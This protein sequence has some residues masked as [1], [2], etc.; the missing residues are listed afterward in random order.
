MKI[1]CHVSIQGG[2][3]KAPE[4]AADLGCE[5]MQMFTRSPQGG[6]TPELTKE[7]QENFAKEMKKH[8]IKDAYVH[9]PYFINLASASGRIYHGSIKAIRDELERASL[10]KAKY[11]MTHIG[12]AKDLGAGEA[13]KKAIIGLKEILKGYKGSTELLIENSA[14]SGAVIGDDFKEVGV[15]LK[16]LKGSPKLSGVCLDTQHSF[17][18]GYDWKNNFAGAIKEIEKNIGKG[19][20]KLMHAN[21]SKTELGSHKDRHENIGHGEIGM[22][23][24]KDI[25]KFAKKNKIDM[26]CE[27]QFPGVVEDIELLK[28]L[29]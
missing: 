3:D 10:L 9:T 17:A 29:R 5:V 28:K 21:D 23:A 24:F 22:D 16:A 4:R 14:G 20:I 12:S 11:V 15:M 25:V 7:I 8:G 27:T 13:T 26:I 1:G 18:S 19:K 6:P 2:V